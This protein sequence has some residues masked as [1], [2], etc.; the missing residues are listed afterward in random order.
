MM[1]TLKAA[2]VNAGMTQ[3]EAGKAIGV[4]ERTIA[5]W[6]KGKSFPNVFQIKKIENVYSITYDQIIFLPSDSV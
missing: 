4:T 6:E 2:R 3:N 5:N 1:M